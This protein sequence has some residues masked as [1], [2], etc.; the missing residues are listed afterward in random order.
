MRRGLF[1]CF[2]IMLVVL[3]GG[4]ARAQGVGA[5]FEEEGIQYHVTK[6][7]EV[8]V[9]SHSSA[10]YSGDVRIPARVNQGGGYAVT[11]IGGVAFNGCSGLKS[12]ELPASVVS[13]GKEAFNACTGLKRIQLPASLTRIAESAFSQCTGLEQVDFPPSL[14][15]IGVNAFYGC[16]SL[17][18]IALPSSLTKLERG[19]FSRCTG[20]TQVEF[21]ASLVSIGGYAFDGCAGLARVELP[22]SLTSIEDGAFSACASLTSI[23]IPRAVASI[24]AGAFGKCKNLR[25]L[26]VEEGNASYASED[27]V[28]FNKERTVLLQF[29]PAHAKTKYSIADSVSGIGD[30]AFVA[31]AGLKSVYVL[32]LTPPSIA[33]TELTDNK[34]MIFYVP[35]ARYDA[36]VAT[37]GWQNYRAQMKKWFQVAFDAA[38]GTLAG[39]AKQIV[40]EGKRVTK[41]KDPARPGYVFMGWRKDA[42]EFNFLSEK[43]TA[44]ITLRAVWGRKVTLDADNGT[45]P[46]I[47]NAE[48]G[49]LLP[50][51]KEPTKAGYAFV[52]WRKD[53]A[54]LKVKFN[55]ATDTVK[56]D[57]TLK[58][59]WGHTVTFDADNWQPPTT[60]RVEHDR[61]LAEPQAPAK[62]GHTFVEWRKD[63]AKFDFLTAT[64]KGDITLKAEW[65]LKE[66]TVTFD[67]D[68][69]EPFTTAT[70]E[71]GKLV[72]QPADPSKEGYTFVEWRKYG[73]KFDFATAQVKSDITLKAVW[74]R[75]KKPPVDPIAPTPTP[76]TPS[77][78]EDDPKPE[79]KPE[80]STPVEVAGALRLHVSPV[81]AS[82]FLT[83]EGM[84]ERAT[85]RVYNP[86][87]Q[88]LLTKDV[89]PGAPVD[90]RQLEAGVYLLEVQGQTVRFVK[91]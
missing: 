37:Y 76:P 6:P 81:P 51:P 13:I 64:V 83:V 89:A 3:W 27:G 11:G 58:A 79:P 55:F 10:P 74:E 32:A 21:P 57:I 23:R 54:N 19:V 41:P 30:G 31:C 80:D 20:L 53:G 40:V 82:D 18:Q 39:D 44:D 36:Y 42:G 71:H 77:K 56:S 46:T 66:Y 88:L 14:A 85:V 59:V 73:A 2:G 25:E 26:T 29:P 65:T 72:P 16:T 8:E 4:L 24:G 1:Y 86:L 33:G 22:A 47:V 75:E 69:G 87:G 70:V 68:N 62:A 52:E 17:R 45:S 5:R 48:D 50:P 43:V 28:L 78:P 91:R 34:D 15:D 35:G 60:V 9:V 49:K 67:A 63:G 90:V 12:I 38:E 7:G 84:T 61:L